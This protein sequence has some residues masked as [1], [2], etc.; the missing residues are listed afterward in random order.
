MSIPFKHLAL[1]FLLTPLMG[2]ITAR[3]GTPADMKQSA[4]TSPLVIELPLDRLKAPE[5]GDAYP[6]TDQDTFVCDDVS[7]PLILIRKSIGFSKQ[8]KLNI[9]TSV[10]VRPSYDRKVTIRYTLI[11]ADGT[12]GP[13]TDQEISAEEKKHS[14][15]SSTLE[16]SKEAFEGLFRGDAHPRLKLVMTVVS[17]R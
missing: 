7:I 17:D 13:V 16:L 10:Y 11:G 5:P 3:Q 9:K 12:P 1:G 14:T 15:D 6:F 2:Q 4:F 8:V